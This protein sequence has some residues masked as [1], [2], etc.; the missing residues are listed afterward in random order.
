MTF[1][2]ATAE[3]RSRSALLTLLVLI[4]LIAGWRAMVAA[5][6]SLSVDEAYYVAWSKSPDF[7]YWTKPPMIA[8]TI[9]AARFL[10]GESA[11]CVRL[12]PVI[13][14]PLSTLLMF[15]LARRLAFTE[16]QACIAALAFATL[17]MSSFYGVAATTDGLLLLYWIASMLFLRIALDGNR[18]AWLV[19]GGCMGLALLSK[20]SAGVFAASTAL[21]ML[22]PSWRH[23]WRSPWSWL[24]GLTALL[25]FSP[26]LWWNFTHGSP[27]FAHTAEI[28]EHGGYSVHPAAMLE[29][30]LAQF[31]VAGPIIFGG[32]LAW[33]MSR[34]WLPDRADS[35]DSWFLLSLSLPF[36]AVISLQALLSRAHANWAAPAMAAACLAAVHFLLA[37]RRWLVA[38]FAVNVLLAVLLY[39]F[40]VL[41]REPFGLQHTVRTDPFWATRSWPNIHSQV[42]SVMRN[43]PAGN[44]SVRVASDDRA[45]LA[46]LQWGLVLPPGSALGWQRGPRPANHFDQHFPLPAKLDVPVLLVTTAPAADV[47]AAFPGAQSAGSARSEVLQGRPLV[48]PMWWLVP[49]AKEALIK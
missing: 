39:H 20:Y 18:I 12:V 27:T 40:D 48:L 49:E 44:G 23:W 5:G 13:T 11:G 16:W 32:F 15:L 1:T 34:E 43:P 38:S 14:F 25:V 17:P 19:A 8:W 28:S 36:I 42:R 33:L 7:G 35:P 4:V 26:N 21:A 3:S 30:L 10:C 41:V 37:R 46:Q 45:V 29:F 9:G 22:H 2:D 24:A 31:I 6:V 47:L